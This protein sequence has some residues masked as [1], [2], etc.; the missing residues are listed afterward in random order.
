MNKREYKFRIW[1][2]KDNQFIDG[3]PPKEYMLD[4]DS[5]WDHRDCDQDGDPRG[6]P[7]SLLDRTFNDRLVIEQ[8]T[9][10]KD[11]EGKDIYDGDIVETIYGY[12][13]LVY[14]DVGTI[15]YRI[16]GNKQSIPII[17]GR[18]KG[19]ENGEIKE[20]EG[21]FKVPT[22]VIGNVHQNVDKLYPPSKP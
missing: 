4:P 19:I 3:I 15:S 10:L 8:Y 5:S 14:W 9:G 17:V 1:D 13:G 22:N 2:T 7:N 20:F 12:V 11:L 6:Y 18:V 16:A 21:I